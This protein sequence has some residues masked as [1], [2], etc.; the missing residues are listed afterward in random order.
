MSSNSSWAAA[1]V[2]TSTVPASSS[3]WATLLPWPHNGQC[4]TQSLFLLSPSHS[5]PPPSSVSSSF[6]LISLTPECF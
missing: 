3:V 1:D 2:G 5:L 4:G 6:P